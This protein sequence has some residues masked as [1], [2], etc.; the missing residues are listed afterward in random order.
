MKYINLN[1][2]KNKDELKKSI[3][4]NYFE[5]MYAR[6]EH[7]KEKME[8]LELSFDVEPN[9][10]RNERNCF[11]NGLTTSKLIIDKLSKEKIGVN[12]ENLIANVS[13]ELEC[14]EKVMALDEYQKEYFRYGVLSGILLRTN[15]K[16]KE[17]Q[18]CFKK[19][20]NMI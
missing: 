18:K 12:S 4:R 14:T 9:L 20:N 16:A 19:V 5:R 10:G 6:D 11:V 13:A 8:M 15:E 1:S 2:F 17:Q 7:F 3:E